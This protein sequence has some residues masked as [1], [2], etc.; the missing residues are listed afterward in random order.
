M[1]EPDAA[2]AEG[3]APVSAGAGNALAQ[4]LEELVLNNPGSSGGHEHSSNTARRTSDIRNENSKRLAIIDIAPSRLNDASDLEALLNELRGLPAKADEKKLVQRK[5][6]DILKSLAGN[7]GFY[8]VHVTGSK[9]FRTHIDAQYRADLDREYPPVEEEMRHHPDHLVFKIT[10]GGLRLALVV[11]SKAYSTLKK[12]RGIESFLNYL[13]FFARLFRLNALPGVMM[14]QNDAVFYELLRDGRRLETTLKFQQSI[15]TCDHKVFAETL[16][17]GIVRKSFLGGANVAAHH[18]FK[19]VIGHGATS[20]VFETA[21]KEW[22]VAKILILPIDRAWNLAR[23]EVTNVNTIFTSTNG[24]DLRYFL[25]ATLNPNRVPRTKTGQADDSIAVQKTKTAPIVYYD[26]LCKPI[27]R[28]FFAPGNDY[29]ERTKQLIQACWQMHQGGI[30][31]NDLRVDNLMIN[32]N[33]GDLVIG[34]LGFSHPINQESLWDGGT[35]LTASP[36]L[37]GVLHKREVNG[38]DDTIIFRAAHD[39]WSAVTLCLHDADP[40]AKEEALQ[41]KKSFNSSRRSAQNTLLAMW[42]NT[43]WGPASKLLEQLKKLDDSTMPDKQTYLTLL[44]LLN[45][46]VLTP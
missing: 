45:Q 2:G 20:V 12:P 36:L 15:A 13:E 5:V 23:T 22:P 41:A 29:T 19:N 3:G 26:R 40:D 33:T 25:D 27:P 31:H 1:S 7:T 17:H 38:Q 14:N 24:I 32:P 8:V 46:T 28:N 43:K 4:Q 35:I 37:L 16:Y 9:G 10:E 21:S 34:D 11:E 30:V 39:L 18:S 6:D 42:S 44:D